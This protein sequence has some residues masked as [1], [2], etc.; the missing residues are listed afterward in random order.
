MRSP[1]T[2]FKDA[3]LGE[4]MARRS[5]SAGQDRNE[6]LADPLDSS[7]S[8]GPVYATIIPRYSD[9]RFRRLDSTTAT[10]PPFELREVEC[11]WSENLNFSTLLSVCS[12]I[13]LPFGP[14]NRFGFDFLF[15]FLN[16][17]K[18]NNRSVSMIGAHK[19]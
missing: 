1:G 4:S 5:R 19:L 2:Q 8:N 13:L 12:Q 15:A 7:N 11:D 10:R 3:C 16:R 18:F 14:G 6:R 17:S 9:S